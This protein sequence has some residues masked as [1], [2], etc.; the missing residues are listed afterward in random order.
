[1]AVLLTVELA[2]KLRD[3]YKQT[4]EK[5]EGQSDYG[6]RNAIMYETCTD[7]GVCWCAKWIFKHI[8]S[9][10]DWVD[11]KKIDGYHW[12]DKPTPDNFREPLQKRISILQEFIDE[13]SK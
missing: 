8:L 1:M 13:F 2:T 9:D 6:K 3:H 4:L 10:C 11:L 5:L 12:C 7:C